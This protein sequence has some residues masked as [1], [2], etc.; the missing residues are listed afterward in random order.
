MDVADFEQWKGREVARLLALVETERRYYQEIVTSLPVGLAVVSRQG[1]LQSANRSFRQTFGLRT[2]DVRRRSLGQLIDSPELLRQVREGPG[3]P[4]MVAAAGRTFRTTV[5][6]LRRWDEDSEVDALI[7]LEDLTGLTASPVSDVPALIWT[8]DPDS[9]EFT[10]VSGDEAA[11][12]HP[13]MRSSRIQA[14]DRDRVLAFYRHALAHPGVH[15][16]EYRALAKSG[17][18]AWYRDVFRVTA[19]ARG[20][21]TK[22]AGVVTDITERKAAEQIAVNSSR[23]DAVSSLS[24][25]I[26]HDLNNPLMIVTGYGEELLSSL[27]ESDPRRSELDEILTAARRMGGLTSQLLNFTR[28]QAQAAA[29]VALREVLTAAMA[30]AECEVQAAASVRVMADAGQLSE[31]VRAIA[32]RLKPPAIAA[33]EIALTETVEG[34]PAAGRYVEVVFRG[35]SGTAPVDTLLPAKDPSASAFAR[36]HALIREWEGGMWQEGSDVHVVLPAAPATQATGEPVPET[37]APEEPAAR[38]AETILVVEDEDGIRALVRKILRRQD[39]EVLE[40]GTPDEAVEVARQHGDRIQLLI[41]D[42]MLP[43]R[44]G[45]QLAE[46]LKRR[47]PKLKVLYVSGYTD[48]P[49]VYESDPPAGAAFLQKPFTIGSLLKKVRD[50]LD[51]GS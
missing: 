15:A 47:L 6:L 30:G 17:E 33:R 14:D 31:A 28:R 48:D 42:M 3:Q 41:T 12:A 25:V 26:T 13:G 11:I 23:L 19:D 50:V 34:G 10:V 40:A 44:S 1:E 38:P 32:G 36:A 45:R 49:S 18:P 4:F 20:K 2:E 51:Q 7:A 27:D 5:R 46:E 21:V 22:A 37:T 43:Q 24:K 39:Y 35:G 16:C 29:P 8:A 9:L